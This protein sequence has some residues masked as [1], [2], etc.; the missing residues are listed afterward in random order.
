MTPT[1]PTNTGLGIAARVAPA[2]ESGNGTSTS[3]ISSSGSGWLRVAVG[4]R[5]YMEEVEGLSCL[6]LSS[7]AAAATSNAPALRALMPPPSTRGDPQQ[8]EEEEGEAD[9]DDRP[10]LL[11]LSAADARAAMEEG[12][13]TVVYVSVARRLV[14]M[15]A[16]ADK[17]RPEARDTVAALHRMGVEVRKA[18]PCFE[19]N[20]CIPPNFRHQSIKPPSYK[21]T[22][23]RCGC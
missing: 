10:A 19:R 1:R 13:K 16:V 2:K 8:E 7:A 9:P 21:P 11:L 20:P 15:I 18:A 4:N 6:S 23:N 22:H 3:T 5:R 14:G 12:G 17:P